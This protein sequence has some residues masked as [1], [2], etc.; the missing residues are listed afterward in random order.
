[1]SP[2]NI[3][4]PTTTSEQLWAAQAEI[5]RLTI[6]NAELRNLVEE[7][8]GLASSRETREA[9]AQQVTEEATRYACGGLVELPGGEVPAIMQN[10]G[11]FISAEDYERLQAAAEASGHKGDRIL[12]VTVT[13]HAPA[14]A[15]FEMNHIEG[16]VSVELRR[17]IAEAFAAPSEPATEDQAIF[18]AIMSE[19]GA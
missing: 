15:D 3:Q 6:E 17:A 1:M 4:S 13:N 2:L 12:S 8:R 18:T 11:S 9:T 5:K 19:G 16:H 7:L 14:V 10:G